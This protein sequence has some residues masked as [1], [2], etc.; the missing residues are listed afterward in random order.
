MMNRHELMIILSLLAIL[1]CTVAAQSP[2]PYLP[3]D[4]ADVD[5]LISD[6]NQ[7]VLDMY[8]P[9]APDAAKVLDALRELEGAQAQ[10]QRQS[11]LSLSRLTL[12]YSIVYHDT[13]RDP[14]TRTALMKR[15]ER[16]YHNVLA[17]APL[18]L[19]NTVRIAEASLSADQSKQG[20][21]R[22]AEAFKSQAAQAG[23][24]FNIDHIDGYAYGA[25]TPGPRPE[26]QLPERP[27]PQPLVLTP[28]TS[29]PPPPAQP[30]TPPPPVT[31]PAQP[32]V[33]QVPETPKP[34]TPP[35]PPPAVQL[36]RPQASGQLP[37][38][39][40]VTDWKGYLNTATAK[41]GFTPAQMEAAQG[42]INQSVGLAERHR[43]LNKGAYAEVEAL[44][45][46]AADRAAKLK[47]LNEPLDLLHSTMVKRVD[48]IASIEQRN[49]AAAQE[50]PA[51][52]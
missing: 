6:R 19:R 30:A 23:E 16:Q 38:A 39:P 18:S 50:K 29:A 46:D 41:Y 10:Y 31:P 15:F 4:S 17:K 36:P 9:A 42:V 49:R 3:A 20:Q 28:D 34:T 51:G 26:I 27:A 47:T 35:P 44:P 11:S 12:A 33:A 8:Q 24:P 13:N 32:P 2:R 40:P 7:F 5:K 22:M 14:A 48:A 43:E 21:T 25:I 37:T 52:Q 45:A 1:P